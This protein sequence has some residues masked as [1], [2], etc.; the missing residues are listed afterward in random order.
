MRYSYPN[1]TG[2]ACPGHYSATQR[3]RE[4]SRPADT[5]KV[6]GANRALHMIHEIEY[7]NL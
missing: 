2:S 4:V 6:P 3:P 5:K 1:K 7:Q